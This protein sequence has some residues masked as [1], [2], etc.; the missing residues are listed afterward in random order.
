MGGPAHGSALKLAGSIANWVWK[1][2]G[3]F[4][5]KAAFA[6]D[7]L[8]AGF[9]DLLTLGAT[10]KMRESLYDGWAMRNLY[11]LVVSDIIKTTEVDFFVGRDKNSPL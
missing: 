11:M 3:S 6:A 10:T 1:N 9:A 7:K 8:I 5:E 2:A 4:I